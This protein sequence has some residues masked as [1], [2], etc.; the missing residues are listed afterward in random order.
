MIQ[1]GLGRR[2]LILDSKLAVDV[3]NLKRENHFTL[4]KSVFVKETLHAFHLL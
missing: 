3:G 2:S 1:S 4:V